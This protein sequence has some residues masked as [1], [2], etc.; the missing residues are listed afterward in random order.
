VDKETILVTGGFGFMGSDFIQLI[1]KQTDYYVV[2]LDLLTYAGDKHNLLTSPRL[3]SFVVDICDKEFVEKLFIKYKFSRVVHFAAE[4]HVD[5]SIDNPNPFLHSNVIGT[6]T[7]LEVLKNY[8]DTH[9]HLISTDEVYGD[10]K[11]NN[12]TF[13][14]DSP[15]RPSSPYAASKASADLFCQT[16]IR[17]Y[18]AKIT[19]SR[20][21]NNYGP[22]QN[23]EKLIPKMVALAA[24]GKDLPLYGN[25]TNKR[26]WIFVRDHSKAILKILEKKDF[27]K[28]Y[29]IGS[30]VEKTNIE[31]C[32]AICKEVSLQMGK[33]TK[34][35][36]VF[37]KDRLGHDYR[38]S[39]D[40]LATEKDLKFF[41][42][43]EFNQG[44]RYVVSK[45]LS[46][47]SS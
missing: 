2:N 19:I 16:Y 3:E 47:H 14:L 42:E 12:G 1:L 32:E 11:D 20:S 29:H 38:Y 35:K 25:G 37:I 27:G 23:K 34:S 36:I 10:L 31:V 5:N 18:N 45:I 33:Q 39:L 28:I 21:G 41:P 30:G 8:K 9:F 17:T 4:T 44:I 40:L 13:Y 6:V 22:F 43:I 46:E 7:L 24:S 26:D 15:F